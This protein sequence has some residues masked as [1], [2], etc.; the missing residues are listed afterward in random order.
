MTYMTAMNQISNSELARSL[1][2]AVSEE[3]KLITS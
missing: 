2:L 1:F 3:E